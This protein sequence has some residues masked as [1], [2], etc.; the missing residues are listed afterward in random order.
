MYLY[1]LGIC[2]LMGWIFVDVFIFAWYLYCDGLDTN[3]PHN[4]DKS[5]ADKRP[6]AFF[7]SL[8]SLLPL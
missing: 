2:I 1:L 7:A 3:L 4:V 5:M 6:L 8:G